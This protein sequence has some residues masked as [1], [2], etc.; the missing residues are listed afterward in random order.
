[1]GN[2]PEAAVGEW[3]IAR[4][5][6][7]PAP[8]LVVDGRALGERATREEARA[9]V[10]RA[11]Q[12]VLPGRP[13]LGMKNIVVF[14]RDEATLAVEFFQGDLKSGRLDDSIRVCG[15]SAATAVAV[16]QD[17]W[18]A[19]GTGDVVVWMDGRAFAYRQNGDD[20]PLRD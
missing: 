5:E 9:L 6:G 8:T 1:V 19:L 18:G 20:E 3:A 11:R 10:E 16:A 13:D 7:A 14:P 17:V 15:N 12:L 4:A 2:I